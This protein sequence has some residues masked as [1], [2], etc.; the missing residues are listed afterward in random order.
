MDLQRGRRQVPT[1][2]PSGI[3]A[4]VVARPGSGPP[5]LGGLIVAAIVA[6]WG[7]L[8]VAKKT[9]GLQQSDP[10]NATIRTS[11]KLEGVDTL[12]HRATPTDLGA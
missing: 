3:V 4:P 6:F 1:F 9:C 5:F 10:P 12:Q 11:K 2:L 7:G 8:I